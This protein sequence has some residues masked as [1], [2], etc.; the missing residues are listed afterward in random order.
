MARIVKAWPVFLSA[1][2]FLAAFPPLE[3]APLVFVALAPWL[4]S[5]SRTD[6]KGAFRSGYL[7]GF[8]IVFAQMYFVAPLTFRWTGSPWLGY[9][10]W[11][12]CGAVG[13]LYYAGAGWLIQRAL[14]RGWWLA[15]PVIWAGMEVFRSF[16]PGLAFPYFILA[17]PLYQMPPLI[18]SAYWGT[19]YLVSA[20]VA[21]ANVLIVLLILMRRE[22]GPAWRSV[23]LP[24]AAFLALGGLSLLRYAAPV[25]GRAVRFV[26][27]QPGVDLAFDTRAWERLPE[28]VA[29][30]FDAAREQRSR[31]LV[32]PEA[33]VDGGGSIPPFT[34]FAVPADVPVIFGGKRSE[35]GRSYQA[36]FAF[37]GSWLYADKARLV[38][39]GEYVPGRNFL[40]FLEHFKLPAGDLVPG[41]QVS[42]VDVS[43]LRV[44]PLICFEALFFDVAQAQA[45]N[46]AQ[47]LAV[48]SVDDWYMGT[49]APEQLWAASVW[50]AVE[51]GLPVL[52]SAS[53]G[54]TAAIDQRGRVVARAPLAEWYALTADLTV[55]DEPRVVRWRA[56]FPLAAALALPLFAAPRRRSK[57][58]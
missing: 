22:D 28:R 38:V 52:R 53:L 17:H 34:P 51:T 58:R 23:A 14:S 9:V 44:G 49:G 21:L 37:D 7:L 16:V 46:G 5:L 1:L 26:V 56:L 48:M 15:V 19:I 29:Q 32:L 12:I 55:E 6:G 8:L 40:P 33:L 4:W 10:P 24:A 20:W 43:G 36:A 35:S 13:A 41:E 57:T 31:L 45:E 18:Q 25:E 50:R 42:S 30:L 27:G 11:I 54:Y 2:L 47:V 39:F 3:W